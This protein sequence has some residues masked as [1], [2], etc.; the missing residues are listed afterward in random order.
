MLGTTT[1]VEQFAGTPFLKLSL[2]RTRGGMTC[3]I[4]K[5]VNDTA[6]AER[7][8]KEA[9]NTRRLCED[10]PNPANMT[11]NKSAIEASKDPKNND[12]GYLSRK[13]RS[14]SLG[15]GTYL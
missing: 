2:G 8:M 1:Q 4:K 3:V 10:H 13:E 12:F 15:R 6:T 7:G 14:Q 11:T 9:A 5:L